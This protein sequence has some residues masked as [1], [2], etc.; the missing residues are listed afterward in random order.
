[1]GVAFAVATDAAGGCL[2]NP[3]MTPGMCRNIWVRSVWPDFS[4]TANWDQWAKG[5]S[6]TVIP[7]RWRCSWTNS[8][9]PSLPRSQ[10]TSL[11][12]DQHFHFPL[13]GLQV[14]PDLF[15]QRVLELSQ[16]R[17]IRA[18]FRGVQQEIE[19]ALQ[20]GL[21]YDRLAH[22]ALQRAS[23]HAHGCAFEK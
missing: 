6:C 12:H 1:M 7:R 16:V 11:F 8:P 18:E 9:P 20:P 17:L 5:I 22:D 23:K 15:P 19:P 14:E 3:A 21:I 10:P 2:A 13:C 4:A